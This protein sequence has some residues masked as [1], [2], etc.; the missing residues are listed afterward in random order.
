MD[1]D[2]IHQ[3]LE[4]DYFPKRGASCLKYNKPCPHLGTCGL[5]A[6]DE[7][8]KEEEDTIDYDFTYELNDI[9]TDHIKRIS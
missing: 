3:M 1:K 9:I 5:T 2:R 4:L 6:L 7:M 8:R